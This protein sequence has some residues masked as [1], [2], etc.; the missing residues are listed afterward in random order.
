MSANKCKV[1]KK[2]SEQKKVQKAVFGRHRPQA[3]SVHEGGGSGGGGR[4]GGDAA[5]EA[6][7][8]GSRKKKKGGKVSHRN[9]RAF[10]RPAVTRAASPHLTTR[11]E[12]GQLVLRAEGAGEKKKIVKGKRNWL[13][14]GKRK[15][16]KRLSTR[17]KKRTIEVCKKK[18]IKKK[19]NTQLLT[20]TGEF[21]FAAKSKKK[22]IRGDAKKLGGKKRL[23]RRRRELLPLRKINSILRRTGG[24]NTQNLPRKSYIGGVFNIKGIARKERK[25][26]GCI[27]AKGTEKEKKKLVCIEGRPNGIRS[28]QERKWRDASGSGR[29]PPL[30]K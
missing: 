23:Q 20:Y 4:G 17:K 9:E 28:R 3:C 11:T 25:N 27:G 6:R 29:T 15:K 2:S 19:K 7:G 18:K 12:M 10:E 22:R 16:K 30:E 13:T 24:K 26:V 8:K 5:E 1:R 21:S 14:K